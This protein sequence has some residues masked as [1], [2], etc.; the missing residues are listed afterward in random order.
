M[1]RVAKQ[2]H[3]KQQA[4]YRVFSCL[5]DLLGYYAHT[6]PD[7]VAIL[8]PGCPSLKYDALWVRTRDVVHGLRSIGIRRNDRVAVVLPDGPEAAVTM[9]AVATGAVC[10][11]LHPGFTINEYQRYFAELR[12]AALVTRTEI[13]SAS[14]GLAQ[15]LGIPVIDLSLPS[16]EGI[17][18]VNIARAAERHVANVE[19]ASGAEDAFILLT[20]G[21]TARPK[22]VP[23]THASVCLSAYN[24]GAAVTLGPQDRLLHVLP[25]VHGH[26][27]ISGLLGSLAAGSSVVCTSGFD[28]AA[29]FDWLSEF[30]PT[31]YTAVP[32]IHRAVLLAAAER[33]PVTQQ[34]SLRLIRSASSTLPSKVLRG[35]ETAFGVPVIDT[36]GMT[37][38]ATQIAANPMGR[39]KLGSVGRS[40]GAEIAIRDGE[41]R[42]LRPG[43][44]GEIVLRGPTMTRGYE[45]DAG[46]TASAFRDGWFRTGDLGYLDPEGYLFIVGRIKDVV[47]RGGQKVAPAEVEE[48][49]L[50]H[51]DVI[52][53]AVFAVPH[54]R[55]GADVA[56][57]IVLR[58]GSKLS[59]QKLRSFA[60]ERLAGFKVPGLIQIVPEIPKGNGGKVKR[61]ELAA[62]FSQKSQMRA[63]GRN[64]K[65]L[66][67]SELERQLTKIW[68]DLLELKQI[69]VDQDVFALGADSIIV[70]QALSRLRTAFGVDF[71]LKDIFDAPT[72]AALAARLERSA[73]TSVTSPSPDASNDMACI[74]RG[75]PRRASILQE[76]MLRIERALPGLPQFN[77]LAAYRL[78]GALNVSALKRSLTEVISRHDALR[79]RFDWRSKRPV[80][81]IDRAAVMRSFFVFEDLA[82]K[83]RTRRGRAKALLLTKA[84]LKAEQQALT[85]LDMNRAP[86]LRARLLRL[87]ADDHVLLLVVHE[88]AA[89]G[90][91]MGVF[92][93]EVSALYAAFATGRPAQLPVPPLQFSDFARWHHHW[94]ESDAATADVAYWKGHL[95]GASPVFST[96]G[97][98]NSAL[99]STDIARE[100]IRLPKDLTARLHALSLSQGAT[101]FMTL[102]AGFKALLMV[103]S[104]RNDLCIATTMAN[105]SQPRTERVIGPFS[106]TTLIRTRIEPDL[107]F[108]ETLR[109]VRDSVLGAYAKQELP[110]A[111]LAARLAEDE[112]LDAASLNRVFFGIQ[113]TYSRAL[114]LRSV[115][116]R[117]FADRQEQS[118]LRV[119]ST[120]FAVTLRETPSG[121]TGLGTYKSDLFAPGMLRHWIKDYAAI[122]AKAAA[123]PEI[124]LGRLTE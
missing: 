102:L 10:V 98:A 96:I 47:D 13:N 86:L 99:L 109:R 75:G 104:G 72:V 80:A 54:K 79:T 94:A 43:A 70:M 23:L 39:R 46:A 12:I 91:S 51:P 58:P 81:R 4:G 103:R 85:A 45:N 24:V 83:T 26:G 1:S 97:D 34:S 16:S 82:A 88:I 124:S 68:A 74:G 89:D 29:F 63:G 121:I 62:V 30:R 6:A 56:A 32:A 5:S 76:Q 41:G 95:R 64:E 116:V 48:T 84:K 28:A 61:G 35:L 92:M 49:L 53:A 42:E 67:S 52:D 108:K 15:S 22:M 40:A 123:S 106:N 87:G 100:P 18:A 112:G 3:A 119:D 117:P 93:D 9:I 20:S 111:V 66:P 8:A 19:F 122:L 33:K 17:G 60:R 59:G 25:L 107:S 11:P 21:S 90:W 110:F 69:G 105:R 31:W 14:Q 2:L 27:L 77:R 118:I 7:R 71:S 73:K 101:L 114:K 115:T 65:A 120:W 113:N 50:S 55:L 78:R 37:E 38:S 36:Y 44:R 57:A